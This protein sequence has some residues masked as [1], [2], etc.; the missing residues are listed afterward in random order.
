MTDKNGTLDRYGLSHDAAFLPWKK[1]FEIPSYMF[2]I[3]TIYI[4]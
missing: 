1:E 4:F 2:T 3:G